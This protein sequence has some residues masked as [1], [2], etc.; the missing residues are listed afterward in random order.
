MGF[1]I[2]PGQELRTALGGPNMI[3]IYQCVRPSG[4]GDIMGPTG[5]TET[6]T[7][8]EKRDVSG[9]ATQKR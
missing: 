8:Q 6:N 3:A 9:D 7:E 1:E 5:S 2:P 4:T